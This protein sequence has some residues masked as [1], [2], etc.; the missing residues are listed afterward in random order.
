[1]DDSLEQPNAD[2]SKTLISEAGQSLKKDDDEGQSSGDEDDGGIDW[3]K[4]PQVIHFVCVI[5][6]AQFFPVVLQHLGL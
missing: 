6:F 2:F 5:V 4:L 1:M 3:T